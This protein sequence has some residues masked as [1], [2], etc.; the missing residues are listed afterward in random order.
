MEHGNGAKNDLASNIKDGG[1]TQL[2]P[3]SNDLAINKSSFA[4]ELGNNQK[5][6]DIEESKE[7]GPIRK[8]AAS[9]ESK[10]NFIE[11]NRL[12]IKKIIKNNKD[13][14]SKNITINNKGQNVTMGANK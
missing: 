7:A 2:A 6:R 3:D 1:G 10:I 9:K 4:E 14:Y 12:D 5:G 13:D 8:E 11:K